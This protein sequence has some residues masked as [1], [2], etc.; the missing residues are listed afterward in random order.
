MQNGTEDYWFYL[1]I[2]YMTLC[3]KWI[4]WY[5]DYWDLFW[6]KNKED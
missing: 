2:E 3:H 4:K 5:E 1:Y 6:I